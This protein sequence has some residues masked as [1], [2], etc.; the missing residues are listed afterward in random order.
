MKVEQGDDGWRYVMQVVVLKW[1]M[2]VQRQW[3]MLQGSRIP[4]AHGRTDPERGNSE[5]SSPLF[6]GH[7]NRCHL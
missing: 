3:M 6:H 1:L 7:V 2:E 4:I 5:V